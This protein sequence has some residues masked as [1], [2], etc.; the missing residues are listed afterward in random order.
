MISWYDVCLRNTTNLDKANVGVNIFWSGQI[1][2]ESSI[3]LLYF[4]FIYWV[5]IPS[6]GLTKCY[7]SLF[8]YPIFHR[9]RNY[10]IWG[11][12]LVSW[13]SGL[14]LS[15]TKKVINHMETKK[16][17][18]ICFTVYNARL[19]SQHG[20]HRDSISCFQAKRIS[21]EPATLIDNK[22]RNNLLPRI[23]FHQIEIQSDH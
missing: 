23:Q 4:L 8:A 19:R 1:R 14:E 20:L 17:S 5:C 16:I 10:E 13:D 7:G 11:N 12:T 2:V 6:L 9:M 18:G 3:V 22:S 21:R 15:L